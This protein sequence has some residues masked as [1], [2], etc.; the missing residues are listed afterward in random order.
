MN[1]RVAAL[2]SPIGPRGPWDLP[3]LKIERPAGAAPGLVRGAPEREA[4]SRRRGRSSK[5][6]PFSAISAKPVRAGGLSP[7]RANEEGKSD[8]KRKFQ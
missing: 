5:T 3:C 2:A 4:Q 8:A 1:H 6:I 7:S